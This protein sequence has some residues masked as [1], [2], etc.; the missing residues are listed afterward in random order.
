MVDVVVLGS[1]TPNP[2]PDRAGSALAVV[3]DERW[4]L[5]DCGR[6]A[7]LRAITAS[8][9]LAT[10]DA[11]LITHHHSDHLSDLATLASARW[12]AGC[13]AALRVVA[14]AGPAARFA[15]SCLD[16]FDDDCFR[17]QARP[18]CG[19]RPV[20][21]VDEF[22]AERDDVPLT[23]GPW[24]VRSA[25]VDHHPIEPAVGYRIEVDG[26]VIAVSGDTR[27]CDG[28]RR[29][30]AGAAV[31]VHEA[32]RTD[33]VRPAVLRWNAGAASVGRLA[34]RVRPD[35]LVLTH[36]IPAPVSAEDEQAYI[37]EVRG[38]GFHGT[39]LVARDL[40]RFSVA[41]RPQLR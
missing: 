38:A 22:D 31:I 28:V 6:G 3:T 11:V 25:P 30:S 36:L 40:T 37:D 13:S 4:I 10:L 16:P 14:P 5:V 35:V 7:T 34:A 12:S 18:E 27:V 26:V 41:A 23:L 20:I 21:D 29:L 8:L 9:D 17:L 15:R 33:Y 32:V 1:G 39:T 24:L 2:D 19:P